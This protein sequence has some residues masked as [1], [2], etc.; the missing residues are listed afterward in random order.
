MGRQLMGVLSRLVLEM[1]SLMVL[2]SQ[3]RG[4]FVHRLGMQ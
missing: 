2:V 1:Q 4:S 3:K